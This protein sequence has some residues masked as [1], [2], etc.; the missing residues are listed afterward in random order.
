MFSTYTP[1]VLI[2]L[3]IVLKSNDLDRIQ[4]HFQWR[5][6]RCKYS[7]VKLCANKSIA[8]AISVHVS[9]IIITINY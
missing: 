7:A 3:S 2:I 9:T 8:I 1:C 4:V 6:S 5:S